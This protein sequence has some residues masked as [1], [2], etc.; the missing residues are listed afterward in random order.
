[1]ASEKL[2]Q[3]KKITL[4]SDRSQGGAIAEREVQSDIQIYKAVLGERFA[5]AGTAEECERLID[6]RQK[7]QELDVKDR[8]LDYAQQSA[9]IQLQEAKQKAIFQRG[10]Q[11]VASVVSVGVGIYF[12][13]AVPLAGLLFLVLGLA[14]PLG[15]SLEEISGFLDRLKGFPKD[16]DELLS[17]GEEKGIQSEEP[18]NARP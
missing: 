4:L 5:L 10:Q 17:Y 7:I 18:K 1:M 12:L 14:R 11:I 15:Y 8:R 13:Q 16:S 6:L 9:E 2:E 3:Q